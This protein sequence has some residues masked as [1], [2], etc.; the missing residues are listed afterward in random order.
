[1]SFRLERLELEVRVGFWVEGPE[2]RKIYRFGVSKKE[3]LG[4]SYGGFSLDL[5]LL[6]DVFEPEPQNCRHQKNY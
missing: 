2:R 1:M 5:K 6:K 4:K 3:N